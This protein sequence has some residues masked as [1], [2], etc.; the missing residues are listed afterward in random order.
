MPCMDLKTREACCW[1]LLPEAITGREIFVQELPYTLA[2]LYNFDIQCKTQWFFILDRYY[3]LLFYN[4]YYVEAM[5]PC[6]PGYL[7]FVQSREV[8]LG[9]ERFSKRGK[10]KENFF[11]RSAQ[12]CQSWR[13]SGRERLPWI[14]S[15]IIAHFLP[16]ISL[17]WLL[18]TRRSKTQV[19]ASCPTDLCRS[20][21]KAE[22]NRWID[23]EPITSIKPRQPMLPKSF[24]TTLEKT[25]TA[26]TQEVAARLSSMRLDDNNKTEPPDDKPR[27]DSNNE[28]AQATATIKEPDTTQTDDDDNNNTT[29]EDVCIQ[30]STKVPE[31]P[32]STSHH[33]HQHI[34]PPSHDPELQRHQ[35]TLLLSG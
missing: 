32:S 26:A 2:I 12:W 3:I 9:E 20:N 4:W 1:L 18:L 24:Y 5:I 28:P 19:S 34:Y 29:N 11:D 16:S 6:L 27:E 17:R 15:T 10:I 13:S 30:P 25:S 31:S 14:S 22:G 33:L 35:W 21:K 8:A 7:A 23:P